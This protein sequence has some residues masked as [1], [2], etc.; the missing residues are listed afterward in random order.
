[1]I[2]NGRTY[3]TVC[4]SSRAQAAGPWST[5]ACCAVSA[6][7]CCSGQSGNDCHGDSNRCVDR[8]SKEDFIF[9]LQPGEPDRFLPTSTGSDPTYYQV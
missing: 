9:H 5:A 8:T 4:L 3:H 7:T 2:Y 1:M 6:N